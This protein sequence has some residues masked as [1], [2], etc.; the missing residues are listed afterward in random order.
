MSL[1]TVRLFIALPVDDSA[2]LN[3]LFDI[4]RGLDKYSSILKTVDSGNLHITMKFLG[5]VAEDKYSKMIDSFSSLEGSVRINYSL[6]G[7]GCFPSLSS[8]SVIWTGI[9][10]D[11][12]KMSELFLKVEGFCSSFGF[13]KD[14][15]MFTP[16]LTMA[17]VRRGKDVP[18]GLKDF[19]RSNKERFYGESVFN[20]LVFFK[21]K[22]DKEGPEYIKIAEVKLS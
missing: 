14:T 5:D 7:I 18:S 6:K 9:E 15:R 3:Y 16:H 19:I 4:Y 20:R 17:R 12:K 1:K 13:E 22:L 10:C 8:P 11:I 21:S 2:V